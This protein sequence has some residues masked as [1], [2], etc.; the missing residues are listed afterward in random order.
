[1]KL[2]LASLSGVFILA[3]AGSAI[4]DP[5][6]VLFNER[7]PY[8]M[9]QGDQVIGLTGAVTGA[10][11]KKAGIAMAWSEIPATRQLALVKEN[12]A[13]VC[14]VGWFKN[15]DRESF[16]RFTKAI[17]QD[18]PTAILG[19]AGDAR[20]SG[21]DHL[22]KLLTDKGLTLL[23]KQSYS[24]GG[25]LDGKLAALAPKHS[26]TSVENVQM[27]K[28]IAAGRADYM[29]LAEEEGQAMLATPEL[30]GAG[31]S[32]YRIADMPKGSDRYILCSLK[33]PPATI[34]K[35]DQ[36]IGGP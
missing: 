18:K 13:E 29:F 5:I 35:L 16:A 11:F 34:A 12:S 21:I 14:A 25:F 1:M 8:L 15:P 4:A 20:L 28:L 10:A 26:E 24:Y 17:Y 9:R 36:A 2:M 31:L 3:S 23:V 33:V 27:A 7:P 22:D 6:S 30:K 19:R 32:L